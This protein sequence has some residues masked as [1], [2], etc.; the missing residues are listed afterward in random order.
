MKKVFPKQETNPVLLAWYLTLLTTTSLRRYDYY[1]SPFKVS[2]VCSVFIRNIKN[3]QLA[4][5]LCSWFLT[6][7]RKWKDQFLHFF[8]LKLLVFI[9]KLIRSKL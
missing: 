3:L 7:W 5:F 2:S 4:E 6:F 8:L 1:D 9:N